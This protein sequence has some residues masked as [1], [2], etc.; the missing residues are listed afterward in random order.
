MN[1]IS[2]YAF[3]L[4][5][6]MLIEG[7]KLTHGNFAGVLLA[8]AHGGLVDKGLEYFDSMGRVHGLVL[9]V[10]PRGCIVDLLC[11]S[12]N[13]E[14]A[15]EFIQCIPVAS[16]DVVWRILLDGCKLH[17]NGP[18]AERI[19]SKLIELDP[20]NGANYVTII[21]CLCQCREMECCY[22]NEGIDQ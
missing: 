22:K 3:D 13:L 4:F 1:G 10:K 15:Y 7:V 2:D 18:L 20:H 5:S 19:S 14:R 8:C 16:E 17:G 21:K 9:E 11:C 6:Q 12:G